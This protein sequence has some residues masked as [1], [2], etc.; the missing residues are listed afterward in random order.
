M[1]GWLS[2]VSQNDIGIC[3][4][5]LERWLLGVRIWHT[6]QLLYVV[7]LKMQYPDLHDFLIMH[8][9]RAYRALST[10]QVMLN[11]LH[12]LWVTSFDGNIHNV[13][14]C[15]CWKFSTIAAWLSLRLCVWFIFSGMLG[16]LG[17]SCYRSIKL[18]CGYLLNSSTPIGPDSNTS[19]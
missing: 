12:G 17:Q 4:L 14:S 2:Y 7:L 10:S 15:Q 13:G 1:R 19:N 5:M 6:S 16:M 18:L 11:I 9:Q 3:D 8:S